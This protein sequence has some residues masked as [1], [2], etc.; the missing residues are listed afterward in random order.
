MHPRAAR[1]RRGRCGMLG[2]LPDPPWCWPRL[3]QEMLEVGAVHILL[4]GPCHDQGSLPPYLD[5]LAEGVQRQ[6]VTVDRLGTATMPLD[7][8]RGAFWPAERI[9]QAADDLLD[10]VDLTKY[11]LLSVHFGNQEIEQLVPVRWAGRPRPV[12]VYH[13]HSPDWSL[14]VD[15]VPN[16][17]LHRAVAQGVAG[18]DGLVYFGSYARQRLGETP[19]GRLPSVVSFFPSTIP[20]GVSTVDGS[21]SVPVRDWLR[22]HEGMVCASLY[23]FASPWKDLPGLLAAFER[24]HV[25]LR[26]ALAGTTWRSPQYAGVDL[27]DAVFPRT[28]RV[29]PVELTIVASYLDPTQRSAL[30]AATDLAI[31]PYRSHPSFQGSGAIADYLARGVPVV[32]TDVAN[33]R[34]LVQDGGL[35]VTPGD[36]AALSEALDQ[37]AG[38][39][40]LR[41]RLRRAAQQRMHLFTPD[42][43]AA[44]CLAFYRRVVSA[45]S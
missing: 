32:A 5:V 8:Q 35:L 18:M 41:H 6:G 23:G 24:M 20:A 25:P 22:Q 11:D 30:V 26:F 34:E 44:S 19:A 29:G 42:A 1:S 21:G 7:R 45:L 43:H 33:M 3:V 13:V 28:R 4:I 36:P 37:V 39:Q 9:I 16:P 38:D 2:S 12:A 17:G 27:A 14:F 15:Q 10:G 31:V 40:R